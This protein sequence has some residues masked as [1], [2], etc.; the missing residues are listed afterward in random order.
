MTRAL[1]DQA[2]RDRIRHDLDRTLVVEAAAGTGKTTELVQRVLGLLRRG[3]RLSRIVAVTFT[4]KAA[5][6]MKLRLR[7]EIERARALA[8]TSADERKN[9]DDALEE[10]ERAH[11][12]TIHGFCADLLRERPVEA[13]V[14]PLFETADEDGQERIYEQAFEEWF[15]ARLQDP[16]E[17]VRRVLRRKADRDAGG[18]RAILRSAGLA[19]VKQRDFRAPW[20]RERFDREAALDEVVTRLRELGELARKAD[21]QENW[22]TRSLVQVQ[23]FIEDL[24]R[25]EETREG[26]RD[27]DGLE[28]RLRSIRRGRGAKFWGWKGAGKYFAKGILCDDVREKRAAVKRQLDDVLDRADADLAAS[29]RGELD[30]LVR[31]YEELKAR[32]GKLDFLDLLVLTRDLLRD[33][34]AVREEL[35][36]RFSHLLVDEFQD[37][38]PL[39]AEILMLLAADDPAERDYR[40]ARPVP[41]K[42]FVV[43]D[44]KQ[45]IYRF[46]RADVMLYE[47]VKRQLVAAG[48]EVVNLTTSFR[49]APSIQAFVNAAFEPLM[50]GAEDGS[51]AEYAALQPFRDEPEGRPTVVALPAP[52]PYSDWGDW[53]KI[54]NYK[55][56]ESMPAAVAAFVDWLVKDSGW[57]ISERGSD[58]PVPVEARHVCLLF[59][60]FVSFGNDVTRPYVRELEKRR[61]PHVLVGGRSFH[62]R[63]EILAIRNALTAIEWPEDELRVF[64]ALRGPFFAIGDD[65]LLAWRDR[66]HAIHPLRKVEEAALDELSRPVAE[67]LDVLRQLHF[68]RNRRPI[69]DTV[70]RLLEATRAHAGVAIWPTGEQAL[71]NLLRVLDYARRFEAAGATSFRAFVRRLEEDAERG[72]AAEAPVVEEGTDGV[73]IMTVHKAKGL[74]FPVVILVEPTCPLTQENPSRYVDADRG[75]WA[76]PL[77]GCTPIEIVERREQLLAQDVAEAHRLLYVATTRARELLVIPVVGEERM[78]GWV[79]PL[80]PATYPRAE[81]WRAS[82][83]AP[84]CPMFGEDSVQLRPRGSRRSTDDS[85]RPGLHTP[86]AGT[87]GVVWWDPSTLQLDKDDDVGLRQ[88][89]IL[90]A[91]SSGVAASVGERLHREWQEARTSALDEGTKPSIVVRT[92]TQ[93]KEKTAPGR[94]GGVTVTHEATSAA[95]TARPHGKRFGTLVHAVL[96]TVAL[97]AGAE[98]IREM[99]RLHARAIGASEEEV[100]AA[101]SAVQA[102]LEH[103]LLARARSARKVRRESPIALRVEGEIVEGVLDLAFFDGEA[104]TVV[105]FKTDVEIAARR[106]GYEAQVAMYAHAVSVATGRPATAVLLCV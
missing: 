92:V 101:V 31:G 12:G 78:E 49:S 47:R 25:V 16:R 7:T 62:A 22:L 35:Q 45:S 32:A 21:S 18:P 29:L 48:A 67:A 93:E 44:P 54:T 23:R 17:G 52:R 99:A 19:L 24:D 5:G 79:S 43:G 8:S 33:D 59:K 97:D 82:R 103:P 104:W 2:A 4:E 1:A 46:R 14:D 9:L 53:P 51:Q 3:A 87:H 56:E 72:G 28:E 39:Q 63:E 80:H 89:K 106:E 38:D 61:L 96:G 77:A 36:K 26:R 37:T 13:R 94:A 69:A 6:E 73:R 70:A 55:V 42:L 11:I 66:H 71:A 105:D 91:D 86:E 81:D 60:R 74:E 90:R 34:R 68:G 27:Y 83:A 84:G 95:R 65:A 20:R 15:Q 98:P 88:E 50:R 102:A 58:T 64:A 100:A 40:R 41:G 57:K 85:V 75:L 10:L 76:M 30:D